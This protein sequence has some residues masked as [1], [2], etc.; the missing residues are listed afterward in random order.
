MAGTAPFCLYMDVNPVASAIG[1]GGTVT[2]TTSSSHGLW[3]GA[4][5]QMAGMTGAGTAFNGV[6]TATVTSGTAFTYV[7]G[8]ASGTATVT[9]AVASVDLLPPTINYT[10]GTARNNALYIELGSVS[11]GA[12]GDSQ[13][14]SLGFMVHQ[15]VTPSTG[16]WFTTIP[17]QTRFRMIKANTG[18]TP[19]A[20]FSDILFVGF[21]D[22]VDAQLN[23]GGQGTD[24]QVGLIDLNGTLDRLVA[25]GAPATTA[26][27]D[28][29]TPPVSSG[30]TVTVTTLTPHN[31]STSPATNITIRNVIGGGTALASGFNVTNVAVTSVNAATNQFT[32]VYGTADGTAPTSTDAAGNTIN[33]VSITSISAVA[34]ATGFL[35]VVST[36]QRHALTPTYTIGSDTYKTSVVIT[37]LAYTS[38]GT[39]KVDGVASTGA[40]FVRAINGT[41]LTFSL[42]G[43][44]VVAATNMLLPR[45]YD[46][47]WQVSGTPVFSLTNAKLSVYEQA[48]VIP[49]N[50][51]T[52]ALTSTIT[53]QPGTRESDAVKQVLAAA[54]VKHSSDKAVQRLLA[55]GTTTMITAPKDSTLTEQPNSTN[56]VI[57]ASTLRG[58]LDTV[59][60]A[61]TGQD[62]R[63]RR[64]WVDNQA[65]L[66]YAAADTTVKPTFATAPYAIAITGNENPDT[67]GKSVISPFALAI[68]WDHNAV[69]QGIFLSAS[70][71]GAQTL[72]Y[73]KAGYASR[74]GSPVFDQVVDYSLTTGAD[75]TKTLA[76]TASS[77]F[78]ERS[79]PLLAGSTF[80]LRG[81]GTASWNNLGFTAGYAVNG[82]ATV[83]GVSAAAGTMTYTYSSSA[84]TFA[85]GQLVTTAS[86]GL[87]SSGYTVTGGTIVGADST[88]F[89]VAGSGTGTTTG[90]TGTATTFS[91]VNSWQPGQWVEIN[92]GPLALSGLYRI[93]QVD[94][95]LEPGSFYQV[96]RITFN[97]RGVN[98]LTAL[99]K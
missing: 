63:V 22:S 92:A 14:S 41:P 7:F 99:I 90:L 3:T 93:E 72:T 69:K 17:D 25:V 84:G 71:A 13:P 61:Y 73:T 65:R 34:N 33:A 94:W 40:A 77:F 56:F 11:M 27:I 45:I 83:T 82:T 31:F 59:I 29:G 51:S 20:D 28:F 62:Q 74:P 30:G 79:V 91:M 75:A 80:E 23:K 96:V 64:Y 32:Y 10:S 87:A 53:I 70:G 54:N 52:A 12:S 86:L 95:S 58:A 24:A 81:A 66:N 42:S 46:A 57:N 36:G 37:G 76:R 85:V 2:V 5:V 60:E 44:G 47:G 98:T 19:A 4:V 16:P 1:V 43:S 68:R 15:D 55:T 8:T 6:G 35:Q 21:L 49:L 97:R 26:T 50:S 39:F 18:A 48:N 88:T 9:S 67:V 78:L 38:G 89:K